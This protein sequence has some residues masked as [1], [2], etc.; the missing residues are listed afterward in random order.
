[1]IERI[2]LIKLWTLLY[3]FAEF[4]TLVMWYTQ[5]MIDYKIHSTLT[6]QICYRI[7]SIGWKYDCKSDDKTIGIY[8]TPYLKQEGLGLK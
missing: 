2:N 3:P 4:L 6:K 1:M 8:E 5:Y 7:I